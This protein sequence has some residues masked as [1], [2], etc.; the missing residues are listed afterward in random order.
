MNNPV[1]ISQKYENQSLWTWTSEGGCLSYSPDKWGHSP[2]GFGNQSD[3][4][5]LMS[6]IEKCSKIIPRLFLISFQGSA[7]YCTAQFLCGGEMEGLFSI[8]CPYYH[9]VD[10]EG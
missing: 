8:C 10:T 5:F 2:L 9:Q 3:F 7:L 4:P 1:F 6:V